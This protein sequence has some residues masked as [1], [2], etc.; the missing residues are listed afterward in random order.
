[1]SPLVP[2]A[3][4][5]ER[6]LLDSMLETGISKDRKFSGAGSDTD[7]IVSSARAYVSAI[8]K[9]LSWGMRRNKNAIE[10]EGN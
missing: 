4:G 10:L 1:V 2:R 3:D 6:C 8:N 9:L 5:P 7:I